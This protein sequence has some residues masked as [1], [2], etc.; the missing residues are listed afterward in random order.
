MRLDDRLEGINKL[1]KGK[2]VKEINREY[3]NIKYRMMIRGFI[4][5]AHLEIA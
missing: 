1:I 4:V 5:M 2:N 3:Y